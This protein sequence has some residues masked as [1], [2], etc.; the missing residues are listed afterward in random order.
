MALFMDLNVSFSEDKTVLKNIIETAAHLG[1]STVAIN[2]TLEFHHKKQE[3]PKPRPVLDLF[4]KLPVVQGKSK[5]ITVLN[6]LTV[7]ATDPSHFRPTAEYK[8]FDLVAVIPKTEKLF[9][10]ACMNFDVNI[11]C[12]AMS[13][14]LGFFI[15][16]APVNVAIE[17]GVFFEIS[18]TPAIRD[19]TLRRYTISNAL[20]LTEICKGK[21]VIVSSGAEKVRSGIVF[22]LST[23]DAKDAVSTNCRS[24]CLHGKTRSTAFGI[25]HTMKKSQPA[26]KTEE[27]DEEEEEEGGPP[28][29]IIKLEK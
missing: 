15:K 29:K 5:S 16:R 22:G 9:Q 2:Y 8:A 4:E 7:V 6:R 3:I 11:I 23:E 21:N 20:S 12:V 17:R 27:E 24:V 19:S 1:Y 25:I 13:E 18:Y 26:N 14:K 10:A 28:R